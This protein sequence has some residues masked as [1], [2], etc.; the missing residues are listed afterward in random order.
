LFKKINI[1][2]AKI[3]GNRRKTASV[4]VF[5]NSNIKKSCRSLRNQQHLSEQYE[6]AESGITSS[7]SNTK[8]T[9]FAEK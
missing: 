9:N 4:T 8:T 2:L 1:S 5:R 3:P 7:E 6:E